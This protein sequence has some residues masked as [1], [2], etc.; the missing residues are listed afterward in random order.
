MSRNKPTPSPC[1]GSH[2]VKGRY[3]PGWSLPLP[4]DPVLSHPSACVVFPSHCGLFETAAQ[5]SSKVIQGWMPRA[6]ERAVRKRPGPA[7]WRKGT[8]FGGCPPPTGSSAAGIIPKETDSSTPG[9][10]PRSEPNAPQHCALTV[11]LRP[12]V[13]PCNLD[14]SEQ[15][16]S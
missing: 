1:Q 15:W 2:P 14:S 3:K 10:E 4:P 9:V 8:N 12:S 7:A 6:V 11:E 16:N 5:P 13:V